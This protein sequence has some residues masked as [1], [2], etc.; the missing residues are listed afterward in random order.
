MWNDFKAFIAQGNVMELAVAVVIGAAFGKIVSSL[1]DNI[2]M[3]LLGIL[4]SGI[5]FAHLKFSVG[6]AEVLYGEFIQSVFDFLIISFSI[7]LFIR[8]AM[9]FKRKKE[10]EP[11]EETDPQ[12]VLLT[13][14]R[15]LLKEQ[16]AGKSEGESSVKKRVALSFSG[17]KDSCF[18]LHKLHQQNIEVV[19]LF[20][21]VWKENRKT[22]AHEEEQQHIIAQGESLG[23]PVHFIETDFGTYRQDFI[24][25]LEQLK[26]Q[27]DITGA[28]FGDIYLEGHRKWGEEVAKE[29][30]L[31]AL[32]PLWTE[33]QNALD[34]LK[35][36]VASGFKASVI[37]VDTEQLPE[38]WNGRELDA[39]FIADI[40]K[41]D[42][43][44]MGEAGEY[45]TFVY[46][47]PEFAHPVKRN[48]KEA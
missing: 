17:G 30:E 12:E 43:C 14:I 13:E 31:D 2:I 34:L 44:P 4:L 23:I 29:A 41:E 48:Q 25:T 21:T 46:D 5:S 8:L 35:E 26:E 27:Y 1:V 19:C 42:V 38:S 11:E 18:A 7:F 37:K 39:S 9:K 32:Y 10:E 40:E 15:D 22:V 20:T 33:Q 47:G 3:P 36:F 16:Q 6:S 28:A 45:H 24:Q